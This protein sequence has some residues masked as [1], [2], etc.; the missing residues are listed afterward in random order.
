MCSLDEQLQIVHTEGIELPSP[1][2]FKDI[3]WVWD[4]ETL[5]R[6]LPL[7]SVLHKI[8][9][10]LVSL[11]NPSAGFRDFMDKLLC[12]CDVQFGRTHHSGVFTGILQKDFDIGNQ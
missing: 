3:L 2:P 4:I 11:G 12:K 1:D 10:T 9:S 6:I 8:M 5:Q 7:V